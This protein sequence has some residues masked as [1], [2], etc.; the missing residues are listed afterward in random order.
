SLLIEVI[1]AAEA[2][3]RMQALPVAPLCYEE[4]AIPYRKHKAYAAE[5]AILERSFKQRHVVNP[6][7][8]RASGQG[9]SLHSEPPESGDTLRPF[10]V[11]GYAELSVSSI[12]WLLKRNREQS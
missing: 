1:D 12:I 7:V 10:A 11:F 8:A 5:V 4:W 9:C 2:E 3:S 6:R